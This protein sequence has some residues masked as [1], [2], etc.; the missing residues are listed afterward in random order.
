MQKRLLISISI[1]SIAVWL[2]VIGMLIFPSESLKANH[3]VEN[4][5]LGELEKTNE[6][7]D[8]LVKLMNENRT[9]TISMKKGME[10]IEH[11]GGLTRDWVN[12]VNKSG[13]FSIDDL[14][15]SLK[16]KVENPSQSND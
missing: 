5:H 8:A 11:E 15:A 1:L 10:D 14:L 2:A 7:L 6:N 4:R 3:H 13:V 12:Q 16:I 9:P